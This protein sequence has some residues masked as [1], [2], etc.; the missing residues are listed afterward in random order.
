[1]DIY[2][3][4][5]ILFVMLTG[6]KCDFCDSLCAAAACDRATHRLP[7]L[8]NAATWF[9]NS[10][11]QTLPTPFSV[12]HVTFCL[13]PVPAGKP[14][15]LRDVQS[16]RYASMSIRDAPGLHDPYFL[17]ASES[18]CSLVLWMM[19]DNP[20]KRPTADQVLSHAWVAGLAGGGSRVIDDVVRRRMAQLANLR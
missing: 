13:V 16:L 5:C 19:A 9:S 8:C 6:R 11:L 7:D 2:A 17:S 3:L 10:N 15:E 14:F 18:A 20:G 4:G 12:H 1:M